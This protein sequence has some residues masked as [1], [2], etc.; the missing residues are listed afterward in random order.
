MVRMLQQESTT[1]VT[2]TAGQNAGVSIIECCTL[3][4][5]HEA[6]NLYQNQQRIGPHA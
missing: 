2:V 6:L 3:K 1:A 4:Y 5:R